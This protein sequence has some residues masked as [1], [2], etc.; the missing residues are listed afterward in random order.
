[1][2]K[3]ALRANVAAAFPEGEQMRAKVNQV[4]AFMLT[5]PQVTLKVVHHFS[6]GLYARELHIPKG[7]ILTGKIH[8]TRNLNIMLQGDLSVLTPEGV[9]RV[10]APFTI[11]SPPGTKRIAYAHEDTIW[12]T[13][14]A[15]EETDLAKIEEQFIAQHDQEYLDYCRLIEE[16]GGT[17]CLGVPQ[18]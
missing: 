4:E 14:H 15:T 16:Q 10:Q 3:L 7:T 12:T 11:V 8:K 6:D 17:P 9:K 18:Q 13:I 1:M 2:M 5:L